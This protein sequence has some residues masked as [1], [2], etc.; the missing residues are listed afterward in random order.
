MTEPSIDQWR[1]LYDLARQIYALAPWTVLQEAELFG[2]SN[3]DDGEIGFV[4]VMGSAGEHFAIAVYRGEQAFHQFMNIQDLADEMDPAGALDILSVPQIQ[5]SFENRD[6]TT[7]KDRAVIKELGL[8]FRGRHAWPQFRSVVP[9]WL[10][11]YITAEE[12]QFLKVCL[13]QLIA[14]MPRLQSP[15]MFF[16]SLDEN[17]VLVRKARQQDAQQVWEDQMIEI[18]FVEPEVQPATIDPQLLATLQQL[19]PTRNIIEMDIFS[20]LMPTYNENRRPFLPYMLLIVDGRS[21][22]V[23]AEEMFTPD[24]DV[25]SIWVRSVNAVMTQCINRLQVRPTIIHVSNDYWYD[26]LKP[27]GQQARI[28][29]WMRDELPALDDAVDSLMNMFGL[30]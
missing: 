8:K 18:P 9:G 29:L 27:F 23:L 30:F 20:L 16:D 14:L 28:K 12:A 10:P 22:M 24:P 17:R 3:P 25:D 2:V 1:G 11:W 13:E 15:N 4:S 19:P 6:I 5:L 21:G 7:D 26:I